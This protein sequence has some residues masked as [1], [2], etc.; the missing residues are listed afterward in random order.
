MADSMSEKPKQPFAA[1]E[2]ICIKCKEKQILDA[3][4]TTENK[5][6]WNCECGQKYLINRVKALVA[7]IGNH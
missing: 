4:E 5:Y 7:P 6:N 1:L 2:F 3:T